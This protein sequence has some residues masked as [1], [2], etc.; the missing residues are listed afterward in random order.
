MS[1]KNSTQSLISNLVLVK[2]KYSRALYSFEKEK[3]KVN[4]LQKENKKVSKQLDEANACIFSLQTERN[5]VIKKLKIAQ[6][7]LAASKKENKLLSAHVKQLRTGIELKQH[8]PQQQQERKNK[9][10]LNNKAATSTIKNTDKN[11]FEVEKLLKHKVQ[12]KERFF[13]VR[14]KKYDASHDTWERESNLFCPQ[15]LKAYLKKNGL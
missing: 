14:W 10:P 5:M 13:L 15:I 8:Q 11:I 3:A 7:E 4:N 2:A 9:N 6:L 12:R 1:G